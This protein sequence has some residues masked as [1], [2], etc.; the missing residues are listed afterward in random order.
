MLSTPQLSEL[1]L[2]LV[3]IPSESGCEAEVA[4]FMETLAQK[5]EFHCERISVDE[6]RWNLLVTCGHNPETLLT[7]HI[8]TVPGGPAPRIENGVLWGRGSCDAKGIA[9]AMF[10]ALCDLRAAGKQNVGLLLVVGE[11]TRSDGAKAAAKKLAPVKR[12]INGEPTELQFVSGQKGVLKFALKSSGKC[13]H[14]G[15]PEL[16]HSAIHTLLD[17]LQTL[18]NEAWPSDPRVGETLV[19]VGTIEGGVAANVTAPSAEAL[20]MMRLA[21]N[22]EQTEARVRNLLPPTVEMEIYSTSHPQVLKVPPGENSIVVG[23]GSDV[24]HL[25]PL[26]EPLMYG[27]GSIHL[28]HTDNEHVTLADLET[29]RQKYVQLCIE[30]SPLP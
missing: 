21:T 29:A 25:R 27:P 4:L 12:F 6:N 9:A 2:N 8:D 11:E 15:Y 28:A 23:Y 24:P 3:R 1:A 22:A 17:T 14:S 7:T 18:R 5:H 26:G 16:G 13:A 19:N 10:C 20:V 30:E